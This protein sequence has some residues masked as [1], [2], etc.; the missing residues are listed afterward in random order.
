[1]HLSLF[2]LS[3]LVSS[4]G[5]LAGFGG[6]IFMVPIMVMGFDV[7]IETAIGVTALSLFPS[8]ILSTIM[9]LKNQSIDFKLM[10]SLELPTILGAIFGAHLTALIPA[11]PLEIVFSFFLIF[12]AYKVIKPSKSPTALTRGIVFL[13]SKEPILKRQGYQVSL[14]AASF[15]GSVSGVVAGLFGIGGGVL[16]TPIMLNVFKVPIRT[17]TA[18]ALCMIVLTSFVSGVT[19]YSLGHVDRDLL[20][21]SGS[22]FFVGAFV[23]SKFGL[24]ITEHSLKKVV[25]ASIFMAG[26]AT[27]IH[28][29]CLK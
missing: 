8:S 23:G 29:I 19:H 5:T 7:P 26:V 16:K 17:A 21:S 12:L 4:I 20:L 11:R 18:T 2:L 24:K 13:N 22:G 3:M 9:N 28:S 1:M 6:G 10:W 15:F 27:A 14:W 25:A